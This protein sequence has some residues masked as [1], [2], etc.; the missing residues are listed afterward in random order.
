V[1]PVIENVNTYRYAESSEEKKSQSY[2]LLADLPIGF[3]STPRPP[4]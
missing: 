4:R 2:P 1:S 3:A